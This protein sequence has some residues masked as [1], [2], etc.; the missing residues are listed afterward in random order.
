ML[1]DSCENYIY[2]CRITLIHTIFIWGHHIFDS[3]FYMTLPLT[4]QNLMYCRSIG[5]DYDTVQTYDEH[6]HA[7]VGSLYVQCWKL[8]IPKQFKREIM[9][10]GQKIAEKRKYN[11][12]V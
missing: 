3:N 5:Q 4:A 6:I 2:M 9:I 11:S 1:Q 7:N 10:K 12:T 8:V